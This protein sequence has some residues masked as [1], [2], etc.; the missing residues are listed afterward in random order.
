MRVTV[1]VSVSVSVSLSVSMSVRAC[2]C[3][4]VQSLKLS[5]LT[6]KCRELREIQFMCVRACVRVCVRA[7][8]RVRVCEYVRARVCVRE[9]EHSPASLD[10]ILCKTLEVDPV[11]VCVCVRV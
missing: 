1:S 11:Y 8:A 4:C 5:D 7:R 9:R 3:V 10:S 2:V 6:N